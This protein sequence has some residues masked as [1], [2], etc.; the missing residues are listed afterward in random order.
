[1]SDMLQ[2]LDMRCGI[3][4]LPMD[5]LMVTVECRYLS[6]RRFQRY[7]AVVARSSWQRSQASPTNST[8]TTTTLS[9]SIVQ[10]PKRSPEERLEARGRIRQNDAS[11]LLGPDSSHSSVHP[12]RDLSVGLHRIV[13]TLAS[14]TFRNI[15]REITFLLPQVLACLIPQASTECVC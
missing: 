11:T 13:F 12:I 10:R 14:R 6:R 15:L 1:M 2:L 7:H 8:M 4:R 9:L 5:E 3:E